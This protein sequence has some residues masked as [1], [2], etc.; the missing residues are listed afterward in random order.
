MTGSC[1]TC[2]EHCALGLHSCHSPLP[3]NAQEL[4]AKPTPQLSHG[5]RFGLCGLVPCVHAYA[6]VFVWMGDRVKLMCEHAGGLA[7][8]Q[9][10]KT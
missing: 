10:G 2:Q 8:E 3:K 9:E 5:V 6:Y 7:G 1:P 4:L